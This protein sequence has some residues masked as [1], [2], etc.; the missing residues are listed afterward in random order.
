MSS[1]GEEEIEIKRLERVLPSE[2]SLVKVLEELTEFKAKI[3]HQKKNWGVGDHAVMCDTLFQERT[4][5]QYISALLEISLVMAWSTA[6]CER[7]F[8]A[9]N[10]IKT[11]HR[12]CLQHDTV[13]DL[14]HISVNGPTLN[15]FSPDKALELWWT[16]VRKKRHVQGHKKHSSSIKIQSDVH[17]ASV[18]TVLDQITEVPSEISDL[19]S[20]DCE[21]IEL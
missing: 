15:K 8:S 2:C 1:Y 13:D 4:K 7:G 3:C 18:A 9:L 21:L 6:A 17:Q 14:L 5:F 20:T 11:L 10:N 19:S 16:A 12:S